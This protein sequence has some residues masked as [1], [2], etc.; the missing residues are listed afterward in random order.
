MPLP[1]YPKLS[2][3]SSR[4][5]AQMGRPSIIPPDY[6]GEK[7]Q[8]VR[9]PFV[10]GAYDRWGAYWGLPANVWCAW[11]QTATEQMEVFVRADS[12]QAAKKAIR[13]L[14]HDRRS[15]QSDCRPHPEV[16]FYR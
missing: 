3:G 6:D 12:R 2:N 15:W 9:L 13:D 7:L 14:F 4:Y 10:D 16:N 8:L 1:R 5:G 11:G